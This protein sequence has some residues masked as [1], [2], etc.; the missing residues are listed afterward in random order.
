VGGD[1]R[2]ARG[3]RYGCARR[4]T[5]PSRWAACRRPRWRSSPGARRRSARSS[6]SRTGSWRRSSRRTPAALPGALSRRQADRRG[7]GREDRRG[8]HWSGRRD[9][10]A[11]EERGAREAAAPL[12]PQL[13]PA[14]RQHA[15]RL[16]RGARWPPRRSSTR[17]T[18]RS[19]IR[20]PARA[21]SRANQIAEIKPTAELVV[22]TRST[23]RRRLRAVA[24]RPAARARRGQQKVTDTALIPR[25]SEHNLDRMGT[26]RAE[27]LRPG[28]Q[29]LPGD[30][31]PEAVYERTRVETTVSEQV[32]RTSGRRMLV[33]GWKVCTA[34]RPGRT[35][36]RGGLGR[37][38]AAARGSPG[39]AGADALGRVASQGDAAAAG[40]TEASLLAAMETAGKDIGGRGAP[41]GDEGLGHGTPATRA[42]IIERLIDVGYMS[43]RAVRCSPPRRACRSS[44]A[45]LAPAHLAGLTGDWE[46]RLA[47]S[48][49]G[50]QPSRV[51]GR[52]LESSRPTRS[53]AGQAQGRGRSSGPTSALP[54]LRP[55]HH[56]EPQGLFVL[57][58]GRPRMRFR[59]LE[60]E[61][62]QDHSPVRVK[63]LIQSLRESRE[64]G[65]DPGV[66]RTAKPVTGFRGRSGRTFPRQAEARAERGGQVARGVRRG[67]GQG[68]AQGRGGRRRGAGG[69][70]AAT[71]Q[72]TQTGQV[73]RR[74]SSG[75]PTSRRKRTCPASRGC[76]WGHRRGTPARRSSCRCSRGW[77][78]RGL[79]PSSPD[80][81]RAVGCARRITCEASTP[82]A[83]LWRSSRRPPAVRPRPRCPR[84]TARARPG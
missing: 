17:S 65:E 37:R 75:G 72:L 32:F 42:S 34:R 62:Q 67:L 68:A 49:R 23:R 9:H 56:R 63:E 80:A 52:H 2:H 54:R 27:G 69:R 40:Y 83:R 48:S 11:R 41:R 36:G 7:R 24:R 77:C 84:G 26:G 19:R 43:A 47:R 18:R 73:I 20:V 29:A 71:G 35:P 1:E 66:G 28:G 46:R 82:S 70:S 6:P 25:K 4:S 3:V 30:L 44:A 76:A 51:H 53:R 12:R 15:P 74:R 10:Q 33:A 59:D 61:G 13:A 78:R 21:S 50:G 14:P 39:R 5:A 38:P 8:R 57:V 55:R 58:E 60:E 16:P 81:V 79:Q 45:R 31:P 22:T 64:R